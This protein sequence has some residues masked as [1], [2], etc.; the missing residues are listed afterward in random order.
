LEKVEE[1]SQ[2]ARR[3]GFRTAGFR[4]FDEPVSPEK[5]AEVKSHRGLSLS[6]R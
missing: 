6:S 5:I 4:A 2:L 1:I 3:H